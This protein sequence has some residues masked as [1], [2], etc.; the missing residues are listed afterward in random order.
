MA[1][2]PQLPE[3]PHRGERRLLDRAMFLGDIGRTGK[4]SE[5]NLKE[6][7]NRDP[8]KMFLEKEVNQEDEL[9]EK[10]AEGDV[11]EAAVESEAGS[12]ASQEVKDD[13]VENRKDADRQALEGGAEQAERA[14]ASNHGLWRGPQLN[15]GAAMVSV[16]QQLQAQQL[17]KQGRAQKQRDT[18]DREKLEEGKQRVDDALL[19]ALRQSGLAH[20][21]TGFADP[22]LQGGR[23]QLGPEWAVKN[24]VYRWESSP[25]H[26]QVLRW[27]DKESL[28]ETTAAGQRQVIQKLGEQ[29]WSQTTLWDSDTGFDISNDSR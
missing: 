19:Q 4:S 28:L 27:G 13:Q 7:G 9:V 10:K 8:F 12:A 14:T 26:R 22:R 17:E 21:V 24:Q 15:M 11:T 20:P 18:G 29:F 6:A 25:G 16:P 2:G 5:T 23:P 1:L 3:S